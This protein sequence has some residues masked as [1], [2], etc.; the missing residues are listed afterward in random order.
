MQVVPYGVGIQTFNL[1]CSVQV[2]R[3]YGHKRPLKQLNVKLCLDARSI[4]AAS[5]NPGATERFRVALSDGEYYVHAMLATQL[6]DCVK[7]GEM[8]P[9]TI[10]RLIDFL[11]NVV[12]GRK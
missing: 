9:G 12:H 1:L 4:Q 2:R 8:G 11:C 7:S 5:G 10:V 3:V 6:V